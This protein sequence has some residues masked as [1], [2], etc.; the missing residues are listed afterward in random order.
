MRYNSEIH[1]RYSIRLKG[2]DY[3]QAGAYFVTVCIKNRECLLGNIANGE[4]QLNR[5]GNMVKNI[6]N[7]LPTHYPGVLIDQFVIMP[8]HIHGIVVLSSVGAGLCAC[9]NEGYAQH[10]KGQPQG[11]APTP[12]NEK[13]WH[14]NYYEH[15][16]R[17]EDELNRIR[18]YIINNP[19]QWQ[20]DRENSDRIN[21]ENYKKQWGQ[22]EDYIYGK[23]YQQPQTHLSSIL[24][25]LHQKHL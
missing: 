19:L 22:L 2:Y 18:Q 16:I 21:D 6:W 1:H 15:I 11:V 23:P 3:S 24:K 25:L 9:P 17:N 7:N 13:L 4:V 8:N 5:A 10:S 20:F 12:F 14:C